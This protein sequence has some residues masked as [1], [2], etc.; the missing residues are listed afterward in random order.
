MFRQNSTSIAR[1]LSNAFDKDPK[2]PNA[3]PSTNMSPGEPEGEREWREGLLREAVTSHFSRTDVN[4]PRTAPVKSSKRMPI[5]PQMMKTHVVE[6][7]EES[8]HQMEVEVEVE[9]EAEQ[10]QAMEASSL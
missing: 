6:D 9:A 8:K 5:P 2:S 7:E 1:T 3:S 4:S 10:D